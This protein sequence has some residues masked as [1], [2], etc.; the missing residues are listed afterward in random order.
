MR[1]IERMICKGSFKS[2]RNMQLKIFA[3]NMKP[4]VINRI[5]K[6]P[7][8]KPPSGPSLGISLQGPDFRN[9]AMPKIEET[10]D[11]PNATPATFLKNALLSDT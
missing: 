7:V 9:L 3:Q 10:I 5:K 11:V 1:K 8:A 2:M 6:L 4:V